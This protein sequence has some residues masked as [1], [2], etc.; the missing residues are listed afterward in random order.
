MSHP[1]LDPPN[2]FSHIKSEK[3]DR[4][5]DKEYARQVTF[6][7][8]VPIHKDVYSDPTPWPEKKLRALIKE[9]WP[10]RATKTS[11]HYWRGYRDEKP[12]LTLSVMFQFPAEKPSFIIDE[13]ECI[14]SIG[15]AEEVLPL[16]LEACEHA[17]NEFDETR[18]REQ[19]A[20]EAEGLA[21]HLAKHIVA[22]SD[23]A[24]RY[25]QR[26]AA[27]RA[28]RATEVKMHKENNLTDYVNAARGNWDE[29]EEWFQ[30]VV[31]HATTVLDEHLDEQQ[32]H[33]MFR[34]VKKHVE[35]DKIELPEGFLPRKGWPPR[36][37]DEELQEAADNG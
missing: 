30:L 31:Q 21:R 35:A 11:C 22:K 24:V 27:L 13:D 28:E 17:Q 8:I 18:A 29:D 5:R 19:I 3:I 25:K 20:N 16:F 14:E 2:E 37:K 15:G 1:Y 4:R 6:T 36:E 10:S 9:R 23:A 32:S 33:S 7:L 34:G 26:V 12:S